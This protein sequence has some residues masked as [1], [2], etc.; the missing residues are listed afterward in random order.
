M[1]GN[2]L[3]RISIE[4]LLVEPGG[5]HTEQSLLKKDWF[6]LPFQELNPPIHPSQE[7]ID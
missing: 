6:Q 1:E 7:F 2:L 3:L 5:D 4:R